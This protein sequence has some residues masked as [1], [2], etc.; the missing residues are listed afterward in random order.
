MLYIIY[1]FNLSTEHQGV[2]KY[3]FLRRGKNWSNQRK[4]SQSGEENQQQ[5]YP[6]MTQGLGIEPRTHWWEARSL[7]TVSSLFP[8]T[9]SLKQP[10]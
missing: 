10:W 3:W 7:T 2:W 8:I 1:N 5:T 9:N 6:H 4:T